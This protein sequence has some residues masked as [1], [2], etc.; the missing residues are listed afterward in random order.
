MNWTLPAP[1]TERPHGYARYK[2]DRCR[3]YTCAWA[4]SEYNRNRK[5][6]IA[7]GTWRD[8][9]GPVRVHVRSLMAAGMGYK[10]VAAKA[11]VNKSTLAWI[12]YGCG[13][14]PATATTRH[15]IA[16]R[17]LTVE[18]D[19]APGTPVEATGTLRRVQALVALGHT[20]TSIAEAIGWTV[21]NFSFLIHE[22]AV[23]YTRRVEARTA[24]AVSK[25]YDRWSMTR[26]EGPAADR[27]RARAARDGWAPPL[28][29]D[30]DDLDDVLAVP[31]LEGR[32]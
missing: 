14:R 3:C 11:G 2:L 21:Q 23:P 17:L 31:N 27:A 1:A 4:V 13:S 29:W 26:P 16:Q 15:D 24:A 19:I 12:L 9:T 10:R 5:E 8:D 28:A 32:S 30:D 25:L 6:R 20:L 18:L 22:A 7:A